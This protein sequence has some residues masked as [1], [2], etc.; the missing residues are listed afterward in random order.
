MRFLYERLVAV[1]MALALLV[2]GADIATA[3]SYEKA[4]AGFTADSF[5]DTDEAISGVAASGNPLA[6]KV[7]EALQNG[8]LL[9]SPDEKK[10]YIREASGTILDAASGQPVASEPAGLKPVR[11]NN[12]LR[13]SVDAAL[14]SLTLLNPDPAKRFE[15]ALAVFKSR[16]ATALPTIETALA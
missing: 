3:Q 7:I 4:L 10:V 8:R 1:V 14:G 16:D 13:R 15:A 6:I 9:F 12:R 2:A 11:L 5:S